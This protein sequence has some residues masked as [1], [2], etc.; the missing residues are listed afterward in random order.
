MS[1]PVEIEDYDPRW[2]EVFAD[3]RDQISSTLS[4]LAQRIEHVGSTAVPGLAAKPIIDLIVVINTCEDL[5]AVIRN[6]EATGYHH[7]GDLGLPGREAFTT[8]PDMSAHHLYVCADDDLHLA[9]QLLFRD[10]LRTHP[11]TAAAYA[12]LKRSLARQYRYDRSAYT[13]AKSTFIEQTLSAAALSTPSTA[14]RSEGHSDGSNS[15]LRQS[16]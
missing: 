2:P 16:T 10:F 4:G 14:L 3:I 13:D 7:E 8:A 9:R 15:R 6:L 1:R 11:A 12:R 5:H